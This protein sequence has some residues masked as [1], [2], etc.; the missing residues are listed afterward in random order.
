MRADDH[1]VLVLGLTFLAALEMTAYEEREITLRQG[2][3]YKCLA[4]P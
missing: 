2:S 1:E 3:R 4:A